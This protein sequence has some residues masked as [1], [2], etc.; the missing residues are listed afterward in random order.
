MY[1]KMEY[2]DLIRIGLVKNETGECYAPYNGVNSI[3]HVN[4]VKSERGL[5]RVWISNLQKMI[6]RGKLNEAI[7]SMI[8]CVE[9]GSVFR[10]NVINRLCKVIVSEDIGLAYPT[11]PIYC[12]KLIKKGDISNEELLKVVSLL[13]R[14]PKS[15][16]IDE[17][18][19][20]YRNYDKYPFS[21]AFSKFKK[22][23]K[24]KDIE[25]IIQSLNN[26]IEVSAGCKSFIIIGDVKKKQ[27][28]YDVWKYI[29]SLSEGIVYRVNT[30][31]LTLYI[32]Q[33]TNSGKKLNIIQAVFNVMFKDS[34]DWTVYI[35][36]DDEK[37][38]W[39]R[40]ESVWPWSISY[41]S[42]SIKEAEMLGRGME[43]FLKYGAVLENEV[44]ISLN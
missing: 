24:N 15:R 22:C 30:S 1:H 43:Y 8:E 17:V 14:S 44:K 29:L 28:I 36:E 38:G 20:K 32:S 34:I 16:L 4:G 6:R 35:N 39:K 25:G 5:Y 42:H 13:V 10:T 2:T 31:L 12:S 11:L 21:V 9:T 27:E 23:V 37:L 3:L 18:Y 40:D 33:E 41:D 19:L 7:T 26:C